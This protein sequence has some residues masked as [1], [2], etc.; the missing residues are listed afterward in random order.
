MVEETGSAVNLALR[1]KCL[2]GDGPAEGE[3]VCP[4]MDAD[5]PPVPD[6][7]KLLSISVFGLSFDVGKVWLKC[8]G[9]KQCRIPVSPA[10]MCMWG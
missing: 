3:V 2:R 5:A 1:S 7:K 4:V 10:E 8:Q 9:R 6:H